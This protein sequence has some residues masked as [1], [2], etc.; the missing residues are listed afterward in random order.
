[1][2]LMKRMKYINA[3]HNELIQYYNE[4]DNPSISSTELIDIFL[5]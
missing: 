5:R 1:M 4:A 2:L 3:S